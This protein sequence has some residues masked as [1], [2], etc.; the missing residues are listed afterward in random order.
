VRQLMTVAL[1]TALL[2]VALPA[3]A[4]NSMGAGLFITGGEMSATANYSYLLT[5]PG[6]FPVWID[7]L[8]VQPLTVEAG[9]GK[10]GAGLSVPAGESLDFVL[11][12]VGVKLNEETRAVFNNVLVGAALVHGEGWDAGAYFRMTAAK[13]TW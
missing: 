13:V 9:P 11:R 5:E 6:K 4:Q 8:Y 2:L 3:W 1:L 10:F 7:G 12:L